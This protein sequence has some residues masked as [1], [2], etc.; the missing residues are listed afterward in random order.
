[1][2][3]L[4]S[5]P[6]IIEPDEILEEEIPRKVWTRKEAQML[7]D[8]GFPN[9]ERLE[10]IDG[11]LIDRMGKKHAH[12]YWQTLIR[13]WLE[14]NFGP[15]FVQVEPSIYVAPNDNLRNEPAPDLI[16][17]AKSIREYKDNVT[18]SEILLL[19]EVAD[20]TRR[21]DLGKKAKLYAR[22]LIAEYWVVDIPKKMVYLHR[23]PANGVYTSIVQCSFDKQIS[24]L[25]DSNIKVCLD[26]L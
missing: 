4:A 12:N 5:N 24:P 19:I 8:L 11:D 3:T 13:A 21:L 7:V 10:L 25:A 22:G 9:A 20:T 18:P 1:M 2:A 15:E 23:E 6:T 17:T 16:L 14:V 26:Q